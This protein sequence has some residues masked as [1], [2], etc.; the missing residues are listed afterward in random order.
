MNDTTFDA[1]WLAL[2]EPADHRSRA[3][4][5]G[6]RFLAARSGAGPIVD[7][8]AGTGSNARFLQALTGDPLPWRLVDSDAALLSKAGTIGTGTETCLADLVQMP[9]RALTGA[10]GLTAAALLDLVSASWLRA[11]ARRCAAERL[12]VLFALN[13]TGVVRFAPEHADDAAVIAAFLRD[14]EKDKGFGPALG[15]AAPQHARK[16]FAWM[17]FAIHCAPSDW[18]LSGDDD[19][20]LRAYLQG[21]ATAAQ[22]AGS[23]D[24][25]DRIAAW[26]TRRVAQVESCELTVTVGHEDVLAVPAGG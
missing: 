10:G 14:Q 15:P 8:G 24:E 23:N 22:A 9:D 6:E 5:L 21:V 25:R 13:V 26:L 18:V 2:R 17:G 16:L 20:L 3:R 11:L 7:L 19:G 12:P 4:G 1:D